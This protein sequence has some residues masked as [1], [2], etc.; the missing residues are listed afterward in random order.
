MIDRL[1]ACFIANRV[2]YTRHAR[3]E[4]RAEE[5]GFIY[6]QEVYEAVL[7]G[8]VIEDYPDDQPY[9]SALIYGRTLTN[10]PLHIVCA[11]S[12]EEDMAIVITVYHPHPDRWIDNRRRRK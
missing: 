5:F 1:R 3:D 11:Y 8:E 12:C 7:S 9:P 2:L 4:M 6:E 10:R